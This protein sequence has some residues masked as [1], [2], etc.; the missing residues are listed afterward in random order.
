MN[1]REKTMADTLTISVVTPEETVLE[2]EAD[3]VVLPLFDGEIGVLK[4]HSPMIGRLGFGELRL[5]K[6]GDTD[7]YYVDGG[8][9]QV[10]DN[11]VSVLTG[12]SI[13]VGDLDADAAKQQLQDGL[14][15]TASGPE[16]TA[17]RERI[18]SQARAQLRLAAK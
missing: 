17:I 10:A 4:G 13:P 15:R 12:R 3:S 8:F 9:V 7:R 11:A 5:K 14:A 16:E 18:V 2:T 1:K 6:G